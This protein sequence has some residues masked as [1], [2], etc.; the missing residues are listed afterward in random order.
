[1][2]VTALH[3]AATGLSAMNTSLDVIA[4]NIANV[5]TPGFKA[6]RPNLQDLMYLEKQQPGIENA[7]GDT[8]PIGLYVGLG[9]KVS[10][11]QQNFENGSPLSTGNKLDLMIDGQGFFKVQTEQSLGGG[12][13]YTRAGN[14]TLNAD[15]ELVLANDQGR[16]LEPPVSIPDNAISVD[17]D[18]NG[19]IFVTVA[20]ETTP[21]EVGQ[22]EIAT[23]VNPAGLKSVGENLWVETAGSGEPTSGEPGVDA[24][25]SILQGFLENSN[26]DPTLELIQLI[27]TQRAFEFNSNTVRAAD[28]A[29]RTIGQLNR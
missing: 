22:L 7:N 15:R 29:L 16:R 21:Q 26:V 8:R 28:E 11:T 27:R 3:T 5:N 24:R 23:F 14:F 20:G 9:V 4:N 2:S 17:I 19:R 6:F 10:G 18:S 1:M 13:A 12:V 25:G